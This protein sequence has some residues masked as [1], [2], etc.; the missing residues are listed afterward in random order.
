M[1]QHHAHTEL[2]VPLTP[3][4]LTAAVQDGNLQQLI[5]LREKGVEWPHDIAA[6]AMVSESGNIDCLQYVVQQGCPVHATALEKSVT[7]ATAVPAAAFDFAMRNN[8]P[9]PSLSFIQYEYGHD[10]MMREAGYPDEEPRTERLRI[11]LPLTRT[12]CQEQHLGQRSR[13]RSIASDLDM[14]PLRMAQAMGHGRVDEVKYMHFRG[15][16]WGSQMMLN[17]IEGNHMLLL[18][19]A[20]QHGCPFPDD[21]EETVA[22]AA[23]YSLTC[24]MYLAIEEQIPLPVELIDIAAEAVNLSVIIWARGEGCPWDEDAPYALARQG[25]LGALMYVHENGCPV[26]ARVIEICIVKGNAD[27][28]E[29]AI[30][31]NFPLPSEEWLRNAMREFARRTNNA[32]AAVCM[33]MAERVMSLS[34]AGARDTRRVRRRFRADQ[35]HLADRSSAQGRAQVAAAHAEAQQADA[36]NAAIADPSVSWLD[37]SVFQASAGESVNARE[38]LEED[39]DTVLV[40]YENAAQLLPAEHLL[41]SPAAK[42]T[43]CNGEPLLQLRSLGF[44]ADFMSEDSAIVEGCRFYVLAPVQGCAYS[45]QRIAKLRPAAAGDGQ[46]VAVTLQDIAMRPLQSFL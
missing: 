22:L 10:K 43:R 12:A 35:S 15:V 16:T 45:N 34:A 3:S 1:A 33:R 21:K 44:P 19:Y 46:K 28:L 11:L 38:A 7:W 25:A 26:D 14:T 36:V 18:K 2:G 20:V 17:A 29:Y 23:K 27:M 4:M 24:L 5:Y 42:H 41:G 31:R 13:P 9:I 30:E 39:Q 8:F 40:V 37:C 32:S 6:D